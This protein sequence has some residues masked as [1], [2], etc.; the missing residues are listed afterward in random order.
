M[1]AKG[2]IRLYRQS[3]D[4][5]LYHSEPFD[6]WHAWQDLLLMVNHEKK[7]FVSKGKF[8][9][10]EPGQTITSLPILADRWHWSVNRVRRYLRLLNDMGMC[11]THGTSHGTTITVVNWAKYQGRGQA[12]G[13][14]NGTADGYADGYAGGT[15]T[16]MNKNDKEHKNARARERDE[17]FQDFLRLVEE[18]EKN[19]SEGVRRDPED[20]ERQIQTM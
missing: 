20:P 2:W 1:A 6:K 12:D 3:V 15:L 9:E 11:T 7:A 4:N 14:A 13:Y 16:R 18:S 5:P 10:L 8:M 17:M 19:D